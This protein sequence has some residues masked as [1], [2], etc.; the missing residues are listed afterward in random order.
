MGEN[1]KEP[2]YDNEEIIEMS[3]NE[4][5]GCES[6]QTSPQT[7]I[8]QKKIQMENTFNSGAGWFYWIAGFSLI[9][10]AIIFSGSDWNFLVGLGITLI[11][12]YVANEIGPLG[13][14]LAIIL[15]IVIAGVYITF[16]YYAKKKHT[17]AFLTGMI[18]YSLD[19]LICLLA[20]DWLYFGF[21]IFVLFCIWG[22]YTSL[23]KLRKLGAEM[24]PMA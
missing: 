22:G 3:E 20:Q 7:E 11:I 23:R 2:V 5:E 12:S 10:S 8:I 13:I 18:L 9:N 21:H 14:V 15:N 19:G 24:I 1:I 4:T 17:W 6:S 16:G